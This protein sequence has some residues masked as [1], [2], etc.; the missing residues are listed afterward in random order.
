M[1]QVNQRRTK[2]KWFELHEFS[3]GFGLKFHRPLSSVEI[4]RE[5]ESTKLPHQSIEDD[6]EFPAPVFRRSSQRCSLVMLILCERRTSNSINAIFPILDDPVDIEYLETET[7]CSADDG[8]T[9]S[10]VQEEKCFNNVLCLQY[11]HGHSSIVLRLRATVQNGTLA[12]TP[13]QKQRC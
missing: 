6:A 4:I 13:H 9:T 1:L 11:H 8:R 5:R 2:S 7:E 12:S 10:T 3:P